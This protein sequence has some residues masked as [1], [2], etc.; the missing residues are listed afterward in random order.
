V[1]AHLGK[2]DHRV[3]PVTVEGV[4]HHVVGIE[5]LVHAVSMPALLSVELAGSAGT[6]RV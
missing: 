4:D 1:E 3:K 5:E 6:A 2:I